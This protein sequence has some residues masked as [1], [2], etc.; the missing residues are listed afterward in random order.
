MSLSG[1]G[2]LTIDLLSEFDKNFKYCLDNIV[3][4]MIK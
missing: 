1:I 4:S 3:I 2:F